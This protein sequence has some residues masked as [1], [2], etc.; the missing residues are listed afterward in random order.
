MLHLISKQGSL[1]AKI[2]MESIQ[3]FKLIFKLLQ[4]L[5]V[6]TKTV[7][8][9]QSDQIEKLIKGKVSETLDFLNLIKRVYDQL[10][11][12]SNPNQMN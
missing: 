5:G 9:A 12:A 6:H 3:N 8:S 2:D 11:A 4:D 1:K 7:G 10:K